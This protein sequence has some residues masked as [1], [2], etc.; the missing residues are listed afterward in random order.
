MGV[1]GDGDGDGEGDDDDPS[2]QAEPAV[3][4]SDVATS[5]AATIAMTTRTGRFMRPLPG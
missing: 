2:A 5:P 1:D 4:D 3:N